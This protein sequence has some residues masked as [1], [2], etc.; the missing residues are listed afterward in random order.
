M[1]LR[2][3]FRLHAFGEKQSLSN[4]VPAGPSGKNQFRTITIPWKTLALNVHS[5]SILVALNVCVGRNDCVAD[6]VVVEIPVRVVDTAAFVSVEYAPYVR[7]QSPAPGA[8]PLRLHDVGVDGSYSWDAHDLAMA[9]FDQDQSTVASQRAL[10]Q[11]LSLTPLS[12]PMSGQMPI[13]QTLQTRSQPLFSFDE[14]SQRLNDDSLKPLFD[15]VPYSVSKVGSLASGY[16]YGYTSPA[17]KA[18]ALYGNQAQGWYTGAEMVTLAVTT[19]PPTPE[20]TPPPLRHET[21]AVEAIPLKAPPPPAPFFES[22]TATDLPAQVTLLNGYAGSKGARENVNALAANA[23]LYENESESYAGY[24]ATTLDVFGRLLQNRTGPDGA[25]GVATTS[26][27]GGESAS[28]TTSSAPSGSAHPDFFQVKETLG[29]Q[30]D[31]PFFSPS[32]GSTTWVTPL[33]GPIAHLTALYASGDAAR[34]VALDL[35]GFRLTDVHGDVATQEG[36]QISLPVPRLTGWILTGGSLTQTVSDRIAVLEQGLVGNYAAALA[37][38]EPIPAKG[39]VPESPIRPQHLDNASLLSPW[40]PLTHPSGVAL[41]L[42]GGYNFGAVTGC[43][44]TP[45]STPKKPLYACQTQLANHGVGG[46][47][48]RVG[49]L[50]TFGATDTSALPGSISAGGAAR[51]LG[52]NGGLPGS[53]TGFISYGGCPRVSAAYTNAAFPS[54]VPLPQQGNTF[55]AEVDYPLSF[56]ALQLDTAIGAFNEHPVQNSGSATS[57]GFLAFRLTA[58][59]PHADPCAS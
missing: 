20:P 9:G 41:Q 39:V 18:A 35:I 31:D 23:H 22:N 14:A 45:K 8:T 58:A 37:E 1:R 13:A 40:I 51:N 25:I 59:H 17:V 15:L 4:I 19:P 43:G 29:V 3:R 16:A 32:A 2:D 26:Q 56:H 27:F 50:W 12:V 46:L 42:T 5:T 11:A 28:F 21:A 7:S 30:V 44:T 49:N 6:Q 47:F 34:Y 53:V 55:S 10:S 33:N 38:V 36:W 57:G 54:G 52:T 48:F 24:Q